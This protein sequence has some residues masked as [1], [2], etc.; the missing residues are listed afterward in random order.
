MTPTR[1]M[2]RL[3]SRAGGRLV[4]ALLVSWL[5]LGPVSAA[6]EQVGQPTYVVSVVPQFPAAD[7]A[8][9][10]TPILARLSQDLGVRFELKVA[11]DIPS[12]E[13][14]V[15]EGLPDFAYLNPFH[16]VRARRALLRALQAVFGDVR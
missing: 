3:A 10:W 2:M 8:R 9:T 4:S 6:A 5:W 1:L 15:R 12:F 14:E 7:I 16:Q 11:R 13:A